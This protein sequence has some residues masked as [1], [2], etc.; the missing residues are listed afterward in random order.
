MNIVILP[1]LQVKVVLL[2]ML[3]GLTKIGVN[4]DVLRQQAFGRQEGLIDGAYRAHNLS[5][6]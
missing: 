5:I 1:H 6:L 4:C 2:A 3:T